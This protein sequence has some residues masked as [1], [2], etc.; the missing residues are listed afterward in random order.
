MVK[1]SQS[2]AHLVVVRVSAGSYLADHSIAEFRAHKADVP[3]R[4]GAI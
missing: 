4:I 2:Q 1:F 3:M